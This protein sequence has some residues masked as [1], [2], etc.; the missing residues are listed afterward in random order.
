[1]IWYRLKYNDDSVSHRGQ[2]FN[3]RSA[4]TSKD[5]KKRG[6]EVYQSSPV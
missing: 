6:G 5:I 3:F 2:D 1:M 4:S